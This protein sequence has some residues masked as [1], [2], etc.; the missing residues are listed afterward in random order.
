[1]ATGGSDIPTPVLKLPKNKKC[2]KCKKVVNDKGLVCEYCVCWYHAGCEGI[3]DENYDAIQSSGGQTH[4]F[5]KPCN[6]KAIEVLLLVQNMKTEHEKL[7]SDVAELKTKVDDIQNVKG[8][9]GVKVRE[10]VKE[11]VSE[12]S[13]INQRSSNIVV[14]WVEE[15]DDGKENEYRKKNRDKLGIQNISTE[16]EL[17]EH[18]INNVLQLNNV[19]VV[20]AERIGNFKEEDGFKRHLR[21]SLENKRSRN[22]ILRNA[23]KLKDHADWKDV[24]ISPDLT[25]KQQESERNLRD[26]LIRRRQSG[27]QNIMIKNGK[28]IDASAV[29]HGAGNQHGYLPQS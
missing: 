22:Y 25:K 8:D 1:M 13:E 11:E 18:I 6:S 28:I 29:D 14:K 24:Y 26:E 7:R 3:S 9:F 5:C 12:I 16:K 15:L 23:K 27:E 4:W 2:G 19:N 21:V 10:V 20:S 17:G